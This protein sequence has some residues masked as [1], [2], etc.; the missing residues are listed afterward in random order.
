MTIRKPFFCLLLTF[1]MIFFAAQIAAPNSAAANDGRFKK[2]SISSVDGLKITDWSFFA[3]ARVAV[4][5]HVTIENSS[6]TAY[7]D[8]KVKVYYYSTSYQTFGVLVGSTSGVLPI[9]VPPRSKKTYLK[10]GATLG[11]GSMSFRTKRIDILEATPVV[12]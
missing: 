3:A 6:D 9:V 7:K 8:I 10:D 4:I 1:L 12:D 11:A 2:F 5:H